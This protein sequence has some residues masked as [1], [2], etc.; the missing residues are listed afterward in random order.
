MA[1]SLLFRILFSEWVTST[2]RYRVI[3]AKHRR[4]WDGIVVMP[5]GGDLKFTVEAYVAVC[6]VGIFA[7]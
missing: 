5:K 7:P 1:T 3:L 6:R 2:E 4:D